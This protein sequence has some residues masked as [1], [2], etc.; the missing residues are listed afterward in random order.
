MTTTKMYKVEITDRNDK[1]NVSKGGNPSENLQEFLTEM[2]IHRKVR[3]SVDGIRKQ[4]RNKRFLRKKK[5]GE[6]KSSEGEIEDEISK[7]YKELD[8]SEMFKWNIRDISDVGKGEHDV[9]IHCTF[10]SDYVEFYQ[11]HSAMHPYPQTFLSS[12]RAIPFGGKILLFLFAPYPFIDRAAT[13]VKEMLERKRLNLTQVRW[14]QQGLN[15]IISSDASRTI[16]GAFRG[17]DQNNVGKM[18]GSDLDSSP[19]Y[20]GLSSQGDL[21]SVSYL[22]KSR[23]SNRIGINGEK[24]TLSSDLDEQNT[25]DYVLSTLISHSNF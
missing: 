16:Y 6:G 17:I 8:S 24:G 11:F 20:Q 1:N 10:N 3:Y 14:S 13:V 15:A 9:I 21:Y 19:T 18:L 4:I 5:S 7:F 12:F 25:I 2:E 22:S 23:S